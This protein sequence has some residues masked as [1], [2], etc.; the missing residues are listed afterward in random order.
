MMA[1]KRILLIDDD[2]MT[3]EG[4]KEALEQAG[5]QV[6]A[7]TNGLQGLEMALEESPDLVVLDLILPGVDGFEICD[8]LK[9]DPHYANIPII[10][11]TEVFITPEDMQRG[12]Q[13]GSERISIQAESYVPKPPVYPDLLREVR[14][15]LGEAESPA[16]QVV[17]KSVLVVDDD[18]LHREMLKRLLSDAGYDVEMALDGSQGWEQFQAASP[19]LVMLDMQMPGI[20]G[21]ELLAR[22]RERDR[23]VPLI[24]MTAFG[25]ESIA[26]QA[27]KQGADD[28]LIKP[29]EE[30]RIL[31]MIEENLEKA[32][33]RR[34]ARR[35]VTRLRNSNKRLME[36]HRALQAQNAEVQEA[37]RRLQEAEEM[38][39][40][41]VSM[42]VHD[43]K[44]PL[45][46]MLLSIDLLAADFGELLSEEQ[47]DIL[48]STN[49]ASQQMLRLITNLLEVQR[50]E[51]GKMPV[52]RKPLDVNALLRMTVRQSQPLAERKSIELSLTLAESLPLVLADVEL[53]SRVVANLLDNA[54]KFTPVHGRIEVV[55]ATHDAH[56]IV[57][58]TDSGPGIPAGQQARVFEKF[59][60]A[61]H[62]ATR[63]KASV[64]L[65][66]A[67]CKLAVE[68]QE[69]RIWVESPVLPGSPPAHI[70]DR[71]HG[72]ES[73]EPVRG[74]RFV[75]TLPKVSGQ[76][77]PMGD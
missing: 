66:L 77:D 30:W 1:Q 59:A 20:N 15:L 2:Q 63:E 34:L 4:V 37:Y 46:V 41:M 7:A 75:F 14:W 12:L 11:L 71:P 16:Q 36:K 25:S 29:L 27:M 68:V 9:S 24:F 50:L 6:L 13:L 69:G 49:D 57:S 45:N 40:Q 54:I 51:D 56:V 58:V 76:A 55:A 70:Q 26:V 32:R 3:L 44:N 10:M 21:L 48:R 17:K 61:Q 22:I 60:Q 53:T 62:G 28:Y 31:P 73:E 72:G 42:V 74:S 38:R 35:L 67:F 33:L 52:D 18:A 64:G 43:L 23:D 39:Q 8:R 65:G 5:Y 47:R 19:L